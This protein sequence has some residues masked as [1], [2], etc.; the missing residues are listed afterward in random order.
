MANGSSW[1]RSRSAEHAG[2]AV[3]QLL[4]DRQ[5]VLVGTASTA[6]RL[7]TVQPPGKR[8]MPAADWARGVR[9]TDGDR[10]GS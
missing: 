6:V 1:G 4:V 3:G 10:L 5:Q 2:L 7:G 8:A 9:L